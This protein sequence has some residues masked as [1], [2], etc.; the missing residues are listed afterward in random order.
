MD[1]ARSGTGDGVGLDGPTLDRI[2]RSGGGTLPAKSLKGS[3]ILHEICRGLVQ[4]FGFLVDHSRPIRIINSMQDGVMMF[5]V[6][7]PSNREKG[8]K[9][10]RVSVKT[11][12]KG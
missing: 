4:G 8:K 2:L 11:K 1:R 10:K 3:S 7:K 5:V 6:V 12:V 9:S